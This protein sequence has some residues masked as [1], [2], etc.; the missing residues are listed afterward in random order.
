MEGS[1]SSS[2]SSQGNII[3]WSWMI[4]DELTSLSEVAEI[5]AEIGRSG[6]IEE[7]IECTEKKLGGTSSNYK[8]N[9]LACQH[10]SELK[11]KIF[12]LTVLYSTVL[13]QK[14]GLTFWH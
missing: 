5:A 1:S 14:T 3:K 4:D 8:L 2:T 13:K 12:A 9:I 10:L 11:Q 7:Q 6:Q